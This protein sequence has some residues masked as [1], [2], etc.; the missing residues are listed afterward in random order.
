MKRLMSSFGY[1]VLFAVACSSNSVTTVTAQDSGG[2]SSADAFGATGGSPSLGDSTTTGGTAISGAPNSDPAGTGGAA[3]GSGTSI[4]GTASAADG[5]ITGGSYELLQRFGW[6]RQRNRTG[7]T[8]GTGQGGATGGTVTTGGTQATGGTAIGGATNSG[9]AGTGGAAGAAGGSTGAI[10]STP[11]TVSIPSPLNGA[12]VGT[13]FVVTAT[14]SDNVGVAGVQFSLDG[15]P[16]GA[17][18]LAAPYTASASGL[19]AGSHTLG[20]R[21]RDM[22]GNTTNSALVTVTVITTG[23]G[24]FLNGYFPIGVWTQPLSLFDTWK[25]RGVNTM[26]SDSPPETIANWDQAVKNEGFMTIRP[27]AENPSDDVGNTVLLAWAQKDEP[28]MCGEGYVN[29]PTYLANYQAW[30]K[31]DPTRPIYLNFSGGDVLGAGPDPDPSDYA[32]NPDCSP[33]GTPWPFNCSLTSNH[34][35]YINNA[36]DWVSN[37]IYPVSGN[38]PDNLA[39]YDLTGL[40]APIARLQSWTTKPEFS[41]IETA[42]I[43]NRGVT[44]DELRAEVWLAIVYG[45]RGFVYFPDKFDSSGN[46]VDWDGTPDDVA[47]EITKQDAVINSLAPVLQGDINPADL[48]ISVPSPLLACWRKAPSGKYFIVV[49]PVATVKSNVTLTLTGTAGGTT[50]TVFNETPTRTITLGGGGTTITD[51]FTAFAVHVYVVN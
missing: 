35:N 10:D 42:P 21:A 36:L 32:A 18:V 25:A 12:T 34:L 27:P 30:K 3:G 5:T 13:A 37:D 6:H 31:A 46:W 24:L 7:G 29:Y 1:F 19:T 23:A 16:L 2:A 49:N 4:G 9:T 33:N 45:V 11:P 17:E 8:T 40:G 14:A 50:A 48:G 47:K 20:A 26:V 22:A 51:S 38:L 41:Y 44:P 43:Y 39:R 15:S 28:D